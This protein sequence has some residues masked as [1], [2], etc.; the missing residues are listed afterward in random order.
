MHIV[1]TILI[2]EMFS[3]DEREILLLL[4]MVQE[5]SIDQLIGTKKK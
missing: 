3:L 1:T 2:Y 5:Q 4:P